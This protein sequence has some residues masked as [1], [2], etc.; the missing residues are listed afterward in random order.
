MIRYHVAGAERILLGDVYSKNEK[1]ELDASG[2]TA[3]LKKPAAVREVVYEGSVLTEVREGKKT[4]W[5]LADAR[6]EDPSNFAAVREALRQTQEGMADLLGLKLSTIR[7]WEQK[8][9]HP[10]GPA[11]QLIRIAALRPDALLDLY[12]AE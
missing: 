4:T 7:N 6:A 1:P 8:R 5:R 2:A 9:R 12:R 10:R 3:L 11:A